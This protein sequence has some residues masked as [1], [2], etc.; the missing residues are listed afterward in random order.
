MPAADVRFMSFP[1]TL[2]SDIANAMNTFFTSTN[3]VWL[4]NT[5]SFSR[6]DREEFSIKVHMQLGLTDSNQSGQRLYAFGVD[7]V[8]LDEAQAALDQFMAAAPNY[9][10]VAQEIVPRRLSREV[11]GALSVLWIFINAP[12]DDGTVQLFSGAWV[13]EPSSDILPGAAGVALFYESHGA[14]AGTRLV[15]NASAVNTW[16]AGERGYAVVDLSTLE[17]IG[18]P[19]GCGAATHSTLA[20][21][22][23]TYCGRPDDAPLTLTD[24]PTITLKGTTTLAF[25]TVWSGAADVFGVIVL[26]GS[27]TPSPEDI[28]SQTVTGAVAY[29]SDLGVASGATATLSFTGLGVDVRYT[30]YFFAQSPTLGP[31]LQSSLLCFS[32]ETDSELETEA[33][34]FIETEAGVVIETEGAP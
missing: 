24:G 30:V 4:Y 16:T 34:E 12:F 32:F 25:E 7:H 10:P 31:S 19:T 9:Y 23:S 29:A 11:P 5:D 18:L 17:F 2:A 1:G 21:Y 26:E 22:T 13:V 28:I 3:R 8:T 14:E 27:D 20:D 15:R 6:E 33:E